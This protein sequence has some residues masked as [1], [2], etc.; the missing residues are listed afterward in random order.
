MSAGETIEKELAKVRVRHTAAAAPIARIDELIALVD[1][2]SADIA[3]AEDA[4]ADDVIT[5]SLFAVV[6]G[7]KPALDNAVTGPGRELHQ[8]ISKLGK[9][10][11]RVLETHL[12][13]G[14]APPR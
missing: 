3:A 11:D 1:K 13:S 10:C 8:S 12:E 6:T 7:A 9:V 4:E 2:A 5:A 14:H